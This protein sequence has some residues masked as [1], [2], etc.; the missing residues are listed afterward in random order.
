MS[1]Q[2]PEETLKQWFEEFYDW[3][4]KEF[5]LNFRTDPGCDEEKAYIA[6]KTSSY[7]REQDLLKELEKNSEVKTFVE[8]S[9]TYKLSGKQ[10]DL[11]FEFWN[12]ACRNKNI[13]IQKLQERIKELEKKE[14]ERSNP[15]YSFTALQ[16]IEKRDEL[17]DSGVELL[18]FSAGM[19]GRDEWLK[20]VEELKGGAE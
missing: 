8:L 19:V 2:V 16:A 4:A 9:N 18:R 13:E 17:I 15:I 10:H 20:E 1:T 12:T 6:A 11:C 5:Q 7:K 3:A 14:R